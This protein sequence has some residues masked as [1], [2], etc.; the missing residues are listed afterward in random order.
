MSSEARFW[1]SR[2]RWRLRGAWQWPAFAVATVID[3]LIFHILWPG[4]ELIPGFIV[5]SFANLFLVGLVAPWFARR[6]AARESGAATSGQAA[7]PPQEVR[8]SRASTALLGAGVLALLAAGLAAQPLIVSET[9]ATE[10]NARLVRAYVEGH[11][12]DEV[13]RNLGSANTIRLSENYFRTCVALDDPR[14][15]FCMFVDTDAASVKE[16]PNPVPN[17]Q[18]PGGRATP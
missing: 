12:S 6:L 9:E 1:A 3:G 15:A 8:V 17:A 5:A 14:N 16:D 13:Q 2:L 7:V 11:G 4:L 10:A 18:F